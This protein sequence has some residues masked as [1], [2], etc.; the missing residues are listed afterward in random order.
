MALGTYNSGTVSIANGATTVDSLNAWLSPANASPGDLISIDGEAVTVILDN[1]DD[2]QRIEIPEWT[3][4]TKTNVPYVI[5]QMPAARFTNAQIAQNLQK[6]VASLDADDYFVAVK[7][8]A[9]APDPSLG[10]DDQSALQ[11]STGKLWVKEGGL[12]V[13]KGMY[14][15]FKFSPIPWSADETYNSGDALPFQGK[16]WVSL[17]GDNKGNRPDLTD[18]TYWMQLVSNG[19]VVYLAV[20]DSDRPATGEIVLKFVSPKP[21]TFYAGLVDSFA[22]AGIGATNAAV[23]SIE[24]NGVQ[25]GTVSFAAGGGA[26]PQAGTFA[27]PADITFAAGDILTIVA[28]SPRDPTL[29]TVGITLTAYR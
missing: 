27:A 12:W 17:L 10:K 11:R 20:D 6:Q 24:K 18:G 16:T 15:N 3:G 28:P 21:M 2:N 5:F 23:Y 22:N 26:G 8:G 9:A 14:G 19:D 25:F 13:Y 29:S 1:H 4:E 7:A